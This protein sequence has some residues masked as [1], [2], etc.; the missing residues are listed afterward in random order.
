MIYVYFSDNWFLGEQTDQFDNHSD[1]MVSLML[2]HVNPNGS[3]NFD[4]LRQELR[5]K[6][7]NLF[8]FVLEDYKRITKYLERKLKRATFKYQGKIMDFSALKTIYSKKV[9]RIEKTAKS[10]SLE[11]LVALWA[12]ILEDLPKL[13]K[14]LFD[15]ISDYLKIENLDFH[16]FVKNRFNLS[17]SPKSLREI[18]LAALQ[19]K[20]FGYQAE[21]TPKTNM[22]EL[23][24]YFS[25]KGRISKG[26]PPKGTLQIDK[27][28][29]NDRIAREHRI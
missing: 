7:N 10:T 21:T 26:F 13:N 2:K 16:N 3:I 14:G 9:R 6:K 19:A 25:S 11:F 22:A 23:L 15:N 18:M 29:K 20:G 4:S 8:N 12:K 24:K 5:G 27:D 1:I 17:A 28:V